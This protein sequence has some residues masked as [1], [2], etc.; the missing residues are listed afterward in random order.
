MA[1]SITPYVLQCLYQED[2][3]KLQT[4]AQSLAQKEIDEVLGI[5]YFA[6]AQ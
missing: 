2:F 4:E 3:V 1:H 5:N 6:G